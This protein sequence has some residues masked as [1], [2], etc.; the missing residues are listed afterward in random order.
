MR[1]LVKAEWSG[2]ESAFLLQFER[3]MKVWERLPPDVLPDP[4]RLYS[5]GSSYYYLKILL[6][7]IEKVESNEIDL[8]TDC[9]PVLERQWQEV[10]NFGWAGK[11]QDWKLRL[12]CLV[13][14]HQALKRVREVLAGLG[15]SGTFLLDAAS[16][17]GASKFLLDLRP[18][19]EK[20]LREKP[21]DSFP[22]L[23]PKFCL[24]VSRC[25]EHLGFRRLAEKAVKDDKRRADLFKAIKGASV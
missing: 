21:G 11:P 3:L 9:P 20:V 2:G 5:N 17:F 15:K 16:G 23:S 6:P 13:R 22:Y 19:V 24:S 1:K 12:T 4:K 14:T 25:D 7:A 10:S 8:V 18:Y